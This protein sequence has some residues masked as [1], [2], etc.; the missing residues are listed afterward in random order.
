MQ[1]GDKVVTAG[2][3]H[4]RIKE[5]REGADTMLVEVAPG[6]TIKVDR[7][8]VYPFVEAAPAKK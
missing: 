3:I 4:G 7:A 8:S 1:S 2:G 6:V 5:L